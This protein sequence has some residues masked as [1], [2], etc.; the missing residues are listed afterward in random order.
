MLS[1]LA[2]ESAGVGFGALATSGIGWKVAR[3]KVIE[4]TPAVFRLI[5]KL[6]IDGTI[7]PEAA[8]QSVICAI[9]LMTEGN[10]NNAALRKPDARAGDECPICTLGVNFVSPD[11]PRKRCGSCFIEGAIW[12]DKI[13]VEEHER[14]KE[15]KAKTKNTPVATESK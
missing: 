9:A 12:K 11:D 3:S 4:T 6:R 14:D 8:R 13:L 7:L 1:N 2:A 15:E 5:Q 10:I